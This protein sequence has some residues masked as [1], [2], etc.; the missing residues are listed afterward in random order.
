MMNMKSERPCPA[1]GPLPLSKVSAMGR[2]APVAFG[3]Q[4]AGGRGCTSHFISLLVTDKQ[5]EAVS[6]YV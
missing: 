5:V 4:W 6:V 3:E 1:L 2:D